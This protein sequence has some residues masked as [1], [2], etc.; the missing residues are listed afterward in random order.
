MAPLACSD[1]DDDKVVVVA[2]T[3]SVS[4]TI[5]HVVGDADLAFDTRSFTTSAGNEFQVE[6]LQYYLSDIRFMGPDGA[7]DIADV[8]YV[9]G[10]DPSTHSIS[11]DGVPA[12]HY[13]MVALTFGLS[14]ERNVT[15]G[16]DNN[17]ANSNMEWPTNWGGGYHYMKLEGKFLD[18]NSE[19]QSFLTHTGRYHNEDEGRPDEMHFFTVTGALHQNVVEGETFELTITMDLLEWYDDPNQI[20]MAEHSGGIMANFAKQVQLEQNGASVF[21]VE[22]N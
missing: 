20:D 11:I 7:A 12:R 19:E 1:D 3:G 16:L 4:L 10:R 17:S 6:T 5:D 21:D 18:G 15:G 8:H 2:P 14:Q 13:H 9:D 22:V